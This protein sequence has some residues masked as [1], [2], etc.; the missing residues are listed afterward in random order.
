VVHL[1]TGLD[2]GGAEMSLAR[3]VEGLAARGIGNTVVSMTQAG[4]VAAR[5]ESSGVPVVALGLR[6]GAIAPRALLRLR[7]ILA[8][9]RPDVLQT[10]M[11]HADL[12]GALARGRRRQTA[13]VWNL[14]ASNVDMAHYGWLSAATRFACVRLSRWPDTIVVNSAAGM[15]FHQGLGYQNDEWV[16]I[17]N[18]IDVEQ[19]RPDAQARQDIRRELGAGAGALLL[20]LVARVDPMKGHGVFLAAA[21][22]LMAGEPRLHAVV[23]GEGALPDR[24]PFRTWLAAQPQEVRARAHLLGRR[25]DVPR[26]LCALDLACST[27]LFGEG[28][29]NVV[30]EAMACGVPVVASDVGDTAVVVGDC[31]AI[32]PPGDDAAIAAGCAALLADPARR[33]ALGARSRQRIQERFS[34]ESVVARYEAVYRHLGRFAGAAGSAV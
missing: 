33:M 1:I 28:F 20:G 14:R 8:D 11:Y 13:L 31:G 3:L 19:F 32:V 4:P 22:R 21:G 26:L 30:A 16:V 25:A 34:L 23:A 27:S 15:A 18:G 10:W 24:E 5:I 9:R 12:L 2:V 7:R 6:R 29:P 17:P